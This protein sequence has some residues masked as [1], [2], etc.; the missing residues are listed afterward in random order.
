MT[1]FTT[2]PSIINAS[3]LRT[4][5]L[6]VPDD[7]N[8]LVLEIDRAYTDTAIKVNEKTIGL[9]PV[10]KS[11]LTG[12]SWY[13]TNNQ[14]QIGLRQVYNISSFTNFNHMINFNDLTNFVRIFGT[15]TDGT[16]WYTLPYISPTANQQIGLYVSPTQVIFNLG[17]SQPAITYGT[18]VLEYISPP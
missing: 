4:T 1:I 18:V 11:I 17:G 2:N 10:N 14:R 16:K 7:I 12:E 9:F 5:R 3:I 6:F 13:I 15:F 8:K